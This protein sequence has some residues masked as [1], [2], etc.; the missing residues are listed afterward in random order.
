MF[1]LVIAALN[2]NG[3][4]TQK[5]ANRLGEETFA[6]LVGQPVSA[7]VAVYGPPEE[8]RVVLGNRVVIW[9]RGDINT[10]N[11]TVSLTIDDADVITAWDF[12]GSDCIGNEVGRKTFGKRSGVV[13]E[14]SG[15]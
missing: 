7:A 15:K 1:T 3:C 8:E 12:D 13:S 5:V 10:F 4:V 11:C 2:L 14:Q 9:R 6:P